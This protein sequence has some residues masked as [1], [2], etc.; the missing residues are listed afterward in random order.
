[1]P[2]Q[3]QGLK[4]K[5][6]NSMSCC[7]TCATARWAWWLPMWRGLCTSLDALLGLQL[8]MPHSKVCQVATSAA[9]SAA[10]PISL[11]KTV[12]YPGLTPLSEV[13]WHSAV[14]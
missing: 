12:L 3:L 8:A 1:M 6:P 9:T 13:H 2:R 11:M 10:W 7:Q 4:A 5:R 14:S